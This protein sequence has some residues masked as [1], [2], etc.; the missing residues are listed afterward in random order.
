MLFRSVDSLIT[1][2]S[3][4]DLE[5]IKGTFAEGMAPK[6]Q[7]CLDAI[8][9]GAQ[10]VRIIDGTDPAALESALLGVGGTLVMA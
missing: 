4:T 7:A 5:S 6:V 1:D 8:A 10:A 2:I 9:A 3:A